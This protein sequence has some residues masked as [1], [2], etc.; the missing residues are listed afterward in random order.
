MQIIFT[1]QPTNQKDR[2]K[3]T[4]GCLIIID[5][6]LLNEFIGMIIDYKIFDHN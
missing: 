5:H 4:H 6:G 2:L 1:N 3:D